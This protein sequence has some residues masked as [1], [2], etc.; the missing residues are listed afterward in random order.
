MTQ[1]ADT[2]VPA[3]PPA[4]ETVLAADDN[5]MVR[6][7]LRELLA[8]EGYRVL[9]ANC[10]EEALKVCDAH[11]GPVHLLITD[12]TLFPMGGRELARQLQGRYPALKVLYV[13]GYSLSEL[14]AHGLGPLGQDFLKK[15]Y[16]KDV[17]VHKVREILD[18]PGESKASGGPETPPAPK[19]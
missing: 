8:N 6:L 16:T 18:Q 7:T 1:Q 5:G 12:V 2:P 4:R 3:A 11:T 13:S 17:L 15:P 19:T 14:E 9:E 10:A